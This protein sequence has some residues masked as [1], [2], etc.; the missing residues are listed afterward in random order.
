MA[1]GQQGHGANPT[2][3][4]IGRRGDDDCPQT[5]ARFGEPATLGETPNP[6]DEE[7]KLQGEFRALNGAEAAEQCEGKE[8]R[9]RRWWGPAEGGGRLGAKWHIF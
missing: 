4:P 9:C 1:R 8:A 3:R 2:R 7:P 6:G 5:S